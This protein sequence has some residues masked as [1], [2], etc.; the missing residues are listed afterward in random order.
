MPLDPWASAASVAGWMERTASWVSPLV[1]T[2]SRM[3]RDFLEAIAGRY[4][5]QTVTLEVAAGTT[6]TGTLD[7]IRLRA[8][9][10]MG[11]LAPAREMVRWTKR[12]AG[13]PS[14]D[15][16]MVEAVEIESTD[17]EVNGRSIGRVVA[18]ADGIR[19]DPGIT[20]VLITGPISL[21]IIASYIDAV[22]WVAHELPEWQITRYRD[23][24]LAVRG[25]GWKVTAVVRATF[26]PDLKLKT[27]PVGV[28]VFGKMRGVPRRLV[29]KL[30]QVLDIPPLGARLTLKELRVEGERVHMKLHHP[31]IRQPVH[32][33]MIRAAVRDGVATL[34]N[35]AFAP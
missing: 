22:A 23:D 8:N 28:L 29:D 31:G 32:L 18:D 24:L 19:L 25:P 20:P 11:G 33:D 14:D 5:G 10:E 12:V 3:L 13:L 9:E 15:P 4:T 21:R 30:T 16:P 17:V 6:L 1:P 34:A 27:E 26:T 7:A 35:Q 2:P